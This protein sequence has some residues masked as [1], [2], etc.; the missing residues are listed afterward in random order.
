MKATHS[1][2]ATIVMGSLLLVACV[3]ASAEPSAAP[4]TQLAATSEQSPALYGT[5]ENP[6]VWVLAPSQDNEAVFAGAIDI[7]AAIKESTD[8]V[9]TIEY[10][11]AANAL[12]SHAALM[13]AMNAFDYI[14]THAR[15]CAD[16]G[17]IAVH[18]GSSYLDAPTIVEADYPGVLD[19]LIAIAKS[20]PIPN[21][22]IAFSP[23]LPDEIRAAIITA[24]LSLNDTE[25]GL[26]D[27]NAVYGWSGVEEIEDSFYDDLRKQLEDA[28]VTI[29]DL[30]N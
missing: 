25:E 5:E 24:L 6:I 7:V 28:G 14:V 9:L 11:A 4:A 8:L 12:C 20:M 30:D 26:A 19:K 21:D 3:S 13:G 2:L 15:G 29:E 10:A 17:L 1:L 18:A 23:N 16:A 22:A 27:L